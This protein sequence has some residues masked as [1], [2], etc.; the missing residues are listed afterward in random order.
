[1]TIVHPFDLRLF[2]TMR[3]IETALPSDLRREWSAWQQY[4]QGVAVVFTALLIWSLAPAK[5][6][7]LLDLGLS[8][9]LAQLVSSVFKMLIGRPRPRPDLMDPDTFPGPF[10]LYPLKIDG[11]WRLL[12]GWEVWNGA[13]ADMW[14]MPSSH[15]L[16]AAMLSAFLGVLFPR[17]L[18]LFVLAA[19]VVGTGRVVFG[20]HWPTDVIAGWAIGAAIGTVVTRRGCGVRVVDWVWIRFIDR[21]AQPIWPRL[22]GGPS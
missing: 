21:T 6:R 13:G 9:A 7:R 15:S 4:G 10:G 1:M 8:V 18:W 14:S 19:L 12:H 11:Q 20:A 5:R 3:R 22:K 17:G 16:F 2:E